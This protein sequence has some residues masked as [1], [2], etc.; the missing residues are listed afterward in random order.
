MKDQNIGYELRVSAAQEKLDL[1]KESGNQ[2]RID[3]ACAELEVAR[4]DTRAD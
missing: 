1:A 2:K 4:N 3:A